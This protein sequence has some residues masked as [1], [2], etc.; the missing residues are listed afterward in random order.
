MFNEHWVRPLPSETPQQHERR[1]RFP[2]LVVVLGRLDLTLVTPLG[3]S[4]QLRPAAWK[5]LIV[6]QTVDAATPN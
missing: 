2:L 5:R 4:G 3:A 6:A 1:A